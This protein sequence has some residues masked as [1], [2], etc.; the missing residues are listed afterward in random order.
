MK[1]KIIIKGPRVHT[2]GYRYFLMTS[3]FDLGLGGFNVRNTTKDED[4]LV[5]VLTEGDE[6]AIE[7]FK[8]LVESEK[9]E[10]AQVSNIAFEET[11]VEIMRIEEYEKIFTVVLL[12]KTYRLLSGTRADLKERMTI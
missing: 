8:K 1:L 12:T 9:P 11:D 2:V 4:Q 3:A 10:Q 5:V 7:D 6:E